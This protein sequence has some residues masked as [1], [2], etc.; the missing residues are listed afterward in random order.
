MPIAVAVSTLHLKRR[1]GDSRF[2]RR[3]RM[4]AGLKK[5]EFIRL[6]ATRMNADEAT[7]TDWLDGVIETPE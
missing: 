3:N 6:S 4:T 1:T 5:E 2:V 7:A